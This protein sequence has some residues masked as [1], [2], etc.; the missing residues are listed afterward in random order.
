MKL[1]INQE[2]LTRLLSI[3]SRIAGGH[4]TLPILNNILIRTSNGK[5]Q[6]AATNM[7]VAITAAAD[8]KISSEGA[9]AAPARLL[10][11]FVAN[12]PKTDVILALDDNKLSVSAGN[13]HSTINAT[14]ADEFPAL[15]TIAK[16]SAELIIPTDVFKRAAGATVLVASGDTT[17][18]ILTGV[19]F[20]TDGGNLYFT[21]TDGYRLAEM[22]AMKSDTEIK[23]I[24]PASTINDVLRI[25]NDQI[26]EIKIRLDDEQIE[27]DLGGVLINSRL[28]DGQFINYR[29][30]IPAKTDT[31]TIL[32]NAEFKR[33]AKSAE[34]FARD[35][36]GSITLKADKTDGLLSLHS[37]QSEQGENTSNVEA[38]ISGGG[39]ITLNSRFLLDAL[40]VIGSDKVKFQFSGKLAP[41][42]LTA[43]DSD[44]YKHIIM[45]VKS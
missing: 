32:D 43:A 33:A 5:I 10:S 36:A 16:P 26:K 41:T 9:I 27:F 13:Y 45:P 29:Q 12:L 20:Y 31:T 23:A 35:S 1:T 28:I 11:E 42:L 15:P 2:I 3:V 22:K 39:E 37:L 24:V 18:P 6:L 4:T 25:L 21:A 14:L 34:L 38:E 17:R 19:Y 30:L 8:A 44:D 7:E 40:N